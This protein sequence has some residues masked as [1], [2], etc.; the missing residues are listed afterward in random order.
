MHLRGSQANAGCV[1]HG[2][3]HIGRQ[4]ADFGC[5]GVWHRLGA[6]YQDGVAHAGD[7]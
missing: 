3:D 2:F 6:L 7:F 5:T 4:P 1:Q